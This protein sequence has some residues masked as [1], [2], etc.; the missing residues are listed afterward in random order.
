MGKACSK[1]SNE[2]SQESAPLKRNISL[3][4]DI[5]LKTKLAFKQ[6]L[7]ADPSKI[8]DN[9]SASV[10]G[11][12]CSTQDISKLYLF[13]RKEIAITQ[14]AS[15]RKAKLKAEPSKIYAVKTIDKSRL[16]GD[17]SII[18]SELEFLRK[19]DHPNIIQFYEVYQDRSY[20]H[21][22]LEYCNGGDLAELVRRHPRSNEEAVK[23]IVFQI[24]QA[25]SYLHFQGIAHRDV[26]LDNFLLNGEKGG[27]VLKMCDFGLSKKVFD[28][29]TETFK[30]VLGTPEYVAPEIITKKPYSFK[31]DLWS[32]G[33][34]MYVL[35]TG[36]FPFKGSHGSV[37]EEIT[38]GTFDRSP[39]RHLSSQ[40]L[41]F[42]ENLFSVNPAKRYSASD[43]LCD[44]WFDELNIACNAEGKRFLSR[45]LLER[46]QT[47]ETPSKLSNEVIRLMVMMNDDADEVVELKKAFFYV[48]ALNTGVITAKELLKAFKEA[49]VEA[50]L[51]E[52]E[53]IIQSLELRTKNVMTYTEFLV[54][55]V[56]QDFLR[57]EA[58][59][60]QT[61]K[62]F[63]IDQNGFI[64]LEDLENAFN[65]FGVLLPANVIESYLQSFNLD[66]DNRISFD[67]FKM[68]IT[69][70][71]RRTQ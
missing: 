68:I 25:L 41:S 20:V 44:P 53:R 23:R 56:S 21:Y 19:T 54:A 49:E 67:E 65:R 61:F 28:P 38:E 4:K 70:R 6:E 47:F 15:V 1:S 22:V 24:L 51:K 2:V 39:I 11:I 66:K 57:N 43:A 34:V 62:R 36:G 10:W 69:K 18:K 14:F 3:V 60:S 32:T 8:R 71:R 12:T 59:L 48:D 9:E 30:T 13:E 50:D 29:A 42:L 45:Q 17:P 16:K 58:Y 7:E 64:T 5:G 55:A 26:K 63:D 40:G 27:P 35:L 37:F 33:V 31:C 52:M 46:L